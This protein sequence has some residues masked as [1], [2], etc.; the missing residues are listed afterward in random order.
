MKEFEPEIHSTATGGIV[1][2]QL[3]PPA[4]A[5]F[6]PLARFETVTHTILSTTTSTATAAT[7]A[8]IALPVPCIGVCSVPRSLRQGERVEAEGVE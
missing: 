4:K 3:P 5:A 8:A 2:L 1:L 7:A 6:S